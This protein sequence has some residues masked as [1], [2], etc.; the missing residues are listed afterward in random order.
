MGAQN[1]SPVY[2]YR[3]QVGQRLGFPCPLDPI[4]VLPAG[5]DFDTVP[6]LFGVTYRVLV[7]VVTV[8]RCF[9]IS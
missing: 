4:E 9:A 8:T 7:V 2:L 6:L 5:L 3:P 1:T